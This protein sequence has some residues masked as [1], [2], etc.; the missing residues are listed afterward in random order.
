MKTFVLALCAVF[1]AALLGANEPADLRFDDGSNVR[2][3]LGVTSI[4]ALTKYGKLTIPLNEVR[5]VEFGLH[6]DPEMQ[7]KITAAI[8]KLGSEVMRERQ[9]AADEL[10]ALGHFALPAL[11]QATKHADP[12]VSRRAVEIAARIMDSTA[13]ELCNLREEDVIHTLDFSVHGKI[14][15][16]SLKATS[17]HFGETAVKLASLRSLT[18]R[19]NGKL[20]VMLD[21]A[22]YGSDLNS[23]L[24]TGFVIQKGD[25][26][27]VAS[28]GQVDLWPQ[29]PGQYMASPVGISSVAGRGGQFMAGALVGK[30][31]EHGRPFLMGGKTFRTTAADEGKLYLQI[32]PNPWN[33][34]STGSYRVKVKSQAK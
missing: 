26:L 10:T 29:G 4:D 8:K 34:A 5:R 21:A 9:L 7:G 3:K 16:D 28:D 1:F 15:G 25:V 31:G 30:I 14:L 13:P 24:D 20:E 2:V 32:V 17:P 27:D 19:N 23:W 18:I 12:E 22:H 6:I 33:T 11:R